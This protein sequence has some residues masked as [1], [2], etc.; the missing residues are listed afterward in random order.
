MTTWI[1][2]RDVFSEECFG[3]MVAHFKAASIRHHIVRIVPFAHTIDGKA[4]ALPDGEK[5]I[6]Y[7]SI[8]VQK[9]C[10]EQGWLPGV[11]GGHKPDAFSE[12]AYFDALKDDYLLND[13][14]MTTRISK[15]GEYLDGLKQDADFDFFIKPDS[16]SKEFAGQVISR[17][18]FAKWYQGMI[19]I[20]YLDDNDFNVCISKVKDVGNEYRLV[21]VGGEISSGSLYKRHRV[22]FQQLGFP[23][24]L[25]DFHKEVSRIYEPDDVYVMDVAVT[26]NGWKLVEYNT[27]NSAGLYRCNVCKIINDINKFVG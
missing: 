13:D 23:D 24:E 11:F 6:V 2:E 10:R 20:G 25:I 7:G 26:A 9:V 12:S 19:D 1:L 15:V 27:F 22:G 8:G 5:V 3:Q 14:M 16:D 17:S 4:P 21:V 18:G